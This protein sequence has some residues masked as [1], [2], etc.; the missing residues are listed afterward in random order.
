MRTPQWITGVA[1]S[2]CMAF[3]SAAHAVTLTFDDLGLGF[4]DTF[5]GDEYAGFGI[6]FSTPD[7][8]LGMGGTDGSPPNSLG[9]HTGGGN[10]FNGGINMDFGAGNFVTDLSFLIFNTPFEA[11]AYDV[12]GVALT[13]LT[14]GG[15]F[16]ETFDFTGFEVN[17]VIITGT[18]YAIDDVT[19]GDIS[20]LGVPEPAMLGLIGIAL[21]G[22]ARVRRGKS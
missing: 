17:S 16:S 9:A 10:D 2:M 6:N 5:N 3:G 20:S 4:G 18:F 22:V 8:R 13:T 1:L 12:G 15:G 19:F 21:A 7:V 11:T 14:S